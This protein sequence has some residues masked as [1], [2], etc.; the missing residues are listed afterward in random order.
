MVVCEARRVRGAHVRRIGA[1]ASNGHTPSFHVAGIDPKPFL[2]K[3]PIERRGVGFERGGRPDQPKD[4]RKVPIVPGHETRPRYWEAW[5]REGF[6]AVLQRNRRR[7]VTQL[8]QEKEVLV[9][10]RLKRH[11]DHCNSASWR[12]L[13][14][15]PGVLFVKDKAQAAHQQERGKEHHCCTR[16]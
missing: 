12:E 15:L 5:Q 11:S 4:G 3:L 7:T 16:C 10:P 1:R 8:N 13:E 6:C 14:P 9:T 2:S